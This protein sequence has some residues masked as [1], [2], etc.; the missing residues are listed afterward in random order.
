LQSMVKTNASDRVI[1]GVLSQQHTDKQWYPVAYFSKTMALA[2][3]NYGIH[4]KEMLAIIR[5]LDQWRP[6]LKNTAKKIQIFTNYKA[7]KYFI[8]TKQLTER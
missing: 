5:P 2:E 4:D 3:C 8:T 1:A 7:L 6:E